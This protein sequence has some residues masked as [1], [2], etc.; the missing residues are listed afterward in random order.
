MLL[1]RLLSTFVIVA[2]VAKYPYPVGTPVGFRTEISRLH[3]LQMPYTG[4]LVFKMNANGII[5][6]IYEAD[7]IR[8]D[9]LY[10]QIIPVTGGI[11]GNH[12]RVQIG[13]GVRAISINGT[14][15][16]GEISGSATLSGG[17]WT[18]RGVRVHL[19]NPP[20]RT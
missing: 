10:G 12:I 1:S 15:K 16:N 2:V 14:V 11:S 4:A 13:T 6:G 7:S 20:E 3:S 8:P 9:P 17:V 5:N 18:F 19:Q